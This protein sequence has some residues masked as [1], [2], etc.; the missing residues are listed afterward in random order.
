MGQATRAIGNP[1]KMKKSKINNN[2][3]VFGVSV[4]AGTRTRNPVLKSRINSQ[5]YNVSV[6]R[7]YAN[8][9]CSHSRRVPAAVNLFICIIIIVCVFF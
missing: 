2:H 5:R 6:S 9:H 3:R 7:I 8:P 1:R 4:S